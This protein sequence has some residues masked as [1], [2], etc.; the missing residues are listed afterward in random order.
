MTK[1]LLGCQTHCQKMTSSG[2]IAVVM[3]LAIGCGS[4]VEYQL[5]PTSGIVTLDDEPLVGAVVNFQPM[6]TGDKVLATGSVGR[7]D[8]NGRYTLETINEEP[9]AWVGRHKVK[10]F[11]YSPE[12]PVKTDVD[13]GPSKERVPQRYNYRTTLKLEVPAAGTNEANFQLSSQPTK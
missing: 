1:S 13:T 4:Q 2:G 7:T 9:G 10:I 11:S 6:T 8:E 12:T 3:L 5:A